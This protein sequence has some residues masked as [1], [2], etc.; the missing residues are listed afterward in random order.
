MS[1]KIEIKLVK[2]PDDRL[3][4]QCTVCGSRDVGNW[5]WMAQSEPTEGAK[6][7]CVCERCL[8]AGVDNRLRDIAAARLAEAH[9]VCQHVLSREL[10]EAHLAC[11]YTLSLIGR[12]IVPTY[13]EWQNA[14]NA[15]DDKHFRETYGEGLAEMQRRGH[16]PLNEVAEETL[17]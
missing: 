5:S 9:R 14:C 12:L 4:L 16:W 8:K 17:F 1:D 6:P 2:S 13:Q 10:K 7:I 11:E 15:H 3:G